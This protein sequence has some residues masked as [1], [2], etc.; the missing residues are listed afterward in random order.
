MV[1]PERNSVDVVGGN[2][3]ERSFS[4]ETALN[5]SGGRDNVQGENRKR[6]FGLL[7][8]FVKKKKFNYII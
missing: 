5:V 7:V 4:I 1:N 6:L 8:R 3:F 2:M